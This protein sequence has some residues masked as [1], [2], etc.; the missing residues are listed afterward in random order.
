MVY[1]RY[2]CLTTN[3]L[4]QRVLAGARGSNA[5]FK[6]QTLIFLHNTHTHTQ[7]IHTSAVSNTRSYFDH[8]YNQANCYFC[9]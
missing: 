1:A 7:E 6:S 8:K 4:R 5:A 3:V 2:E 9:K